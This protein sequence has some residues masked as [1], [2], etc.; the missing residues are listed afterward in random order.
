MMSYALL[1]DY[2]YMSRSI[3]FVNYI[4]LHRCVPI[5]ESFLIM[6]YSWRDS[7]IC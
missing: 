2:F 5:T 4:V 7:F 6:R 3:C 1:F